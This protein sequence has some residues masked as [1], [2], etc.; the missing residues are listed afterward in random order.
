MP[1]TRTFAFIL[2]FFI[3]EH[4]IPNEHCLE[5]H[6]FVVWSVPHFT[7]SQK[8]FCFRSF[9]QNYVDKMALPTFRAEIAEN[10][11]L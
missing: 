2:L 11:L 3:I 9:M 7:F 8:W 6:Y 10:F 5:K 4:I 1:K